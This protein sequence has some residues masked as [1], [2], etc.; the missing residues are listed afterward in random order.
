M[1]ERWGQPRSAIHIN[2]KYNSRNPVL[3]LED[4]IGLE[5]IRIVEDQDTWGPTHG[6][7]CKDIRQQN[8]D[9]TIEFFLSD[10]HEDLPKEPIELR[11]GQ[12]VTAVNEAIE[13]HLRYNQ[14]LEKPTRL[15]AKRL[16]KREEISND[17]NVREMDSAEDSGEE[18]ADSSYRS[19]DDSIAAQPTSLR[20]SC[21]LETRKSGAS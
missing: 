14:E 20:R 21:R 9:D 6:F 2:L 17:D 3:S 5:I 13:Y 8:P 16:R 12:I 4:A 11:Y 7:S 15:K 19:S 10:L 18:Q 1:A